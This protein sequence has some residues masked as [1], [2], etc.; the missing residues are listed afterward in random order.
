M[1]V[2]N[3]FKVYLSKDLRKKY[4][5]RSF[6][7]A[8]GDIVTIEAGSKKGEGGKVLDINHVDSKVSIE[9]ITATKADGKQ[10]AFMVDPSNLKITRLDLSRQERL[11]K[12]KDLAARKNIIVE[13]E[14]VPEEKAPE[15][16]VPEIAEEQEQP[17]ENV[18]EDKPEDENEDDK[19]N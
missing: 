16:E 1:T 5:L 15:P 11:Q 8:K 6:P 9:G 4:G 14:P 10:K 19:Q 18:E 17:E 3:T 12:I 7:L 2:K 13:E